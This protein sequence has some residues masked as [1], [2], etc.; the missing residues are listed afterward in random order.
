[1]SVKNI[2][3][4]A[5]EDS[6][7]IYA[8]R[9]LVEWKSAHSDQKYHFWG[10]GSELMRTEGFEALYTPSEMAVVGI[11]EVLKHYSRIKSI[12]FEIKNRAQV[13][14][15]DF[16]LLLDYAEFNLRLAQEC[17]SLGLRVI[18]WIPPQVW[19][20]RKSRVSKIKKY[21]DHVVTVFPFEQKF[22]ESYG[23]SSHFFGHPLLDFISNDYY[24]DKKRQMK[25]AQA[26]IGSSN[27]II[28]LMPGSRKS[29]IEQHFEVMLASAHE[30][31]RH[32]K[33]CLFLIPVAPSVEL[34]EIRSRLGKSGVPI[35]I[36]KRKPEDV[37]DLMDM[38]IVASGT[39]TL[40]LGLLK[41][42]MVIIYK[43]SPITAW[44]LK[45]FVKG[46]P[47]FGLPN[48]ILG[49]KIVPE[50]FQS[51][52]TISNIIAP[53]QEWLSNHS[54]KEQVESE[55]ELLRKALKAPQFSS[56]IQGLIQFLSKIENPN[57]R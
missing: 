53:I 22:F 56:S 51:D 18:Y 10:I 57:T 9:F 30:I 38:A 47:F 16:V 54:K 26:G 5:A 25:R 14:R 34:D 33:N 12:L 3:I 35:I 48:L 28:G 45:F 7:A 52:V 8:H 36:Q 49:R 39:A 20:W 13:D 27:V 32:N 50:L 21:V 31:Y 29:E 23:I 37:I 55:L 19:A 43:M 41:K 1:M 44:I 46:V 42:P 4:I 6:S 15:P 11:A 2:L 17:K 24:D 40:L